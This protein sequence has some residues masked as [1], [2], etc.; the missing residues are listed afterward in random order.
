MSL[1][2]MAQRRNHSLGIA[3]AV[4][5]RFSIG[6]QQRQ[7]VLRPQGPG[8]QIGGERGVYAAG[9]IQHRA[10]KAEFMHLIPDETME[11]LLGERQVD[12]QRGARL[13]DEV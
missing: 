2:G 4:G 12:V 5:V 3:P 1:D 6:Q 9:K 11:N 7:H 13:R 8:G 10:L